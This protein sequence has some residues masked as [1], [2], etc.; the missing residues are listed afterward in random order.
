MNVTSA[1]F[2]YMLCVLDLYM[3][4]ATNLTLRFEFGTL[5]TS[6]AMLL[7]GLGLARSN[8]YLVEPLKN[9]FSRKDIMA[10]VT[11]PFG[12]LTCL[13]I[14]TPGDLGPFA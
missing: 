10:V 2:P 3:F 11:Y 12:I 4:A 6:L 8:A 1:F 7:I 14:I 13:F 5:S 9:R